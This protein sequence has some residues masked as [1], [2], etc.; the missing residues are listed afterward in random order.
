MSNEV[1]ELFLRITE[2][3]VKNG[4]SVDTEYHTDGSYEK[5]IEVRGE[6]HVTNKQG[7]S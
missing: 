4:Y 5:W 6:P 2:L 7:Q 1:M 3:L